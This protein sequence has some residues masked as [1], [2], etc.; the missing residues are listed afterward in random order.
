MSAAMDDLPSRVQTGFVFFKNPKSHE[1]KINILFDHILKY[2]LAEILQTLE[3]NSLGNTSLQPDELKNALV[4]LRA[5]FIE[6]ILQMRLRGDKTLSEQLENSNVPIGN[7]NISVS[8]VYRAFHTYYDGIFEEKDKKEKYALISKS[9][10]K[11]HI[12]LEKEHLNRPLLKDGLFSLVYTHCQQS[13]FSTFKILTAWLNDDLGRIKKK[14]A[15]FLNE[16]QITIYLDDNV[17]VNAL[18]EFIKEVDEIAKQYDV[19][20]TTPHTDSP[21]I[22]DSII[23][24]RLDRD[25]DYNYVFDHEVNTQ[26]LLRQENQELYK[27]LAY[28]LSN[29][30]YL[31][32]AAVRDAYH[33]LCRNLEVICLNYLEKYPKPVKSLFSTKHASQKKALDIL[34]K[35]LT[36]FRY[37][38]ESEE[39][40]K[41][42]KSYHLKP[43]HI[44]HITQTLSLNCEDSSIYELP[45]FTNLLSAYKDL[46]NHALHHSKKGEL[47]KKIIEAI[48]TLE[49]KFIDL[50]SPELHDFLFSDDIH[51]SKQYSL[52]GK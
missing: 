28:N 17:D 7:E 9:G 40:I 49:H 31:P 16:A 45:S 37:D 1:L 50:L 51:P 12:N 3:N 21:L 34:I 39:V 18:I 30:N 14:N 27:E 2:K 35:T 42:L 41:T 52:G 26:Q 6:A 10:Q 23:S 38:L 4:E 15:R 19:A 8:D 47:N 11:L 13:T 5:Q 32:I 20:H 36:K 29:E 44:E 25:E 43:Y 46:K 24:Y 48:N 33:D 22:I